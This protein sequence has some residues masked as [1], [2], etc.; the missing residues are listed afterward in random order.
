M[1][2]HPRAQTQVGSGRSLK[3]LKRSCRRWQLNFATGL[4]RKVAPSACAKYLRYPRRS[5]DTPSSLELQ[6]YRPNNYGGW[7]AYPQGE[8]ANCL[9]AVHRR[10]IWRDRC[11]SA[12]TAGE[13]SINI[14]PCLVELSHEYQTCLDCRNLDPRCRSGGME[15]FPGRHRFIARQLCDQSRCRHHVLAIRLRKGLYGPCV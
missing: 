5:Q 1:T 9:P 10:A 6:I 7:Q 15:L 2:L 8:P 13:L 3:R 14:A 11:D 12:Q 4:T